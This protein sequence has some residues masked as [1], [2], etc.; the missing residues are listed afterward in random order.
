VSWFMG[1]SFG[2]WAPVGR[3]KGHGAEV[4]CPFRSGS[5]FLRVALVL[6]AAAVLDQFVGRVRPRVLAVLVGG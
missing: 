1:C 4:P 5:S 2:M 3:G 6:A